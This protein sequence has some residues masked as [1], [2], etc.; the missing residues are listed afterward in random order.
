MPFFYICN[1]W[2][3]DPPSGPQTVLSL[4]SKTIQKIWVQWGGTPQGP[5]LGQYL[6]RPLAN[7]ARRHLITKPPQKRNWS[8]NWRWNWMALELDL[9]LEEVGLRLERGVGWGEGRVPQPYNYNTQTPDR[10]PQRL[11][12]DLFFRLGTSYANFKAVPSY[13]TAHQVGLGGQPSPMQHAMQ[14]TG[15]RRFHHIRH[16]AH[17][18]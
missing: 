17:V 15:H 3:G 7:T 16:N 8:R 9:R 2:W 14:R 10:P 6:H 13:T 5:P 4:N 11:L 18:A 1:F 12:L